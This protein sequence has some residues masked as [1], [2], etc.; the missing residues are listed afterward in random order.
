MAAK[1]GAVID[2]CLGLSYRKMRQKLRFLYGMKAA[3]SAIFKWVKA[4]QE[5]MNIRIKAKQR[6]A[7]A[8]DESVVKI[9]G[10]RCWIWDAIDVETKELVA[11]D[12]SAGR[13]WLDSC[14]KKILNHI[15]SWV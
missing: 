7:V 14:M 3:A 15:K 9:C 13:S 4:F 10:Y 12:T 6:T 5:R 1:I 2:Y 11:Y 8:V